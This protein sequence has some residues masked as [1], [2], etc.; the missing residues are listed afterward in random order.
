MRMDRFVCLAVLAGA[1]LLPTF[2]N[3]QHSATPARAGKATSLDMTVVKPETVGFSS[4]RLERLHAL[5]QDEIDRR[6]LRAR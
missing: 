5:I 6:S 4:E 3:A 1:A 2:A